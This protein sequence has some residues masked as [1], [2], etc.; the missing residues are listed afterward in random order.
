MQYFCTLSNNQRKDENSRIISMYNLGTYT[1]M[2]KKKKRK[3]SL[4]LFC[5]TF[6]NIFYFIYSP[7]DFQLHYLDNIAVM[8]K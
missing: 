2:E 8:R 3:I 1:Y 5:I 7:R 4:I 6:K